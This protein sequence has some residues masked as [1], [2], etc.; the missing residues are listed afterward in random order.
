MVLKKGDIFLN[1]ILEKILQKV[2]GDLQDR[3]GFNKERYREVGYFKYK[4]LYK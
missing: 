1:G 3:Q 4:K 2:W